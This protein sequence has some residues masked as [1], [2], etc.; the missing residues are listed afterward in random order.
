VFSF[1]FPFRRLSSNLVRVSF[2]LSCAAV[3]ASR[4]QSTVETVIPAK[5]AGQFVSSM[6]I[7]L[8]ME[9]STAPYYEKNYQPI[10]LRLQSLGIR[11]V[12]D[13]MNQADPYL[14]HRA[15]IREIHRIGALGYRLTGLMEGNDYPGG[16]KILEASHVLPMILNLWPTID[17]LE[18]PNEPDNPQ[19]E[20][21]V[22]SLLYPW[23]AI[24]ES[25]DLWDI[26][27]HGTIPDCDPDRELRKHSRPACA[28]DFRGKSGRLYAPGEKRGGGIDSPARPIL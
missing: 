16:G 7:N 17:S 23:V 20:Y 14:H 19:F 3:T 10:N 5:P 15:F 2:V 13:E 28:G 26:V 4:G 21:G 12:R 11:Q 22:A 24:Q 8:H 27:K 9:S 18:G 25:E 6:G 1:L